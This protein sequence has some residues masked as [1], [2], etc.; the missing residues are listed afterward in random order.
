V[1]FH[2]SKPPQLA[3][4]ISRLE[5]GP[6]DQQE[7]EQLIEKACDVE[8]QLERQARP[9]PDPSKYPGSPSYA[10]GLEGAEK[11]VRVLPHARELVKA[12]RQSDLQAA[13]AAARKIDN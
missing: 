3:E 9:I 7:Q 10:F 8:E 1:I 5:G 11:S 12:L 6:I 2:S 13:L 4:I